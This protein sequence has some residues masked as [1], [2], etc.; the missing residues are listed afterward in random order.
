VGFGWSCARHARD[1][2][3]ARG[4]WRRA[5]EINRHN[6]DAWRAL[7]WG[8]AAAGDE[9]EM[10]VALDRATALDPEGTKAFLDR[11]RADQPALGKYTPS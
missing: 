4:S 5:A 9:L 1:I 11:S 6:A 8:A 10:T 3:S 2:G 7:A